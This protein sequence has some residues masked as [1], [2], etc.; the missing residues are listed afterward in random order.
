MKLKDKQVIITGAGGG[1]GSCI[2]IAFA[3]KGAN[4]ALVDRNEEA[5]APV[6]EKA[7]TIGVKAVGINADI[8]TKQGRDLIIKTTEEELG[9]IDI[10]VNNAGIMIFKSIAAHTEEEVMK[11]LTVNVF[12][13]ISLTQAV[14]GGMHAR[15]S[16]RIVN[17]GSIFASL[18]FPY[19]GIYSA[20][21]AAIKNF[22]EGLRRELHGTGIG[23]T[24]VAPRATRTSQTN[25]FFE[26][27]RKMKMNL[28]NPEKVAAIVVKS[29]ENDADEVLI[30][31]PERLF[32][33]INKLRP[34]L[35]DNGLLKQAK[36]MSEYTR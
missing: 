29:I 23:V 31:R 13:T 14:L 6:L 15:G 8:T 33:L 16:G 19:F 12:G 3:E 34:S 18:A 30:G 27:A 36:I 20:S 5:L 22:S 28:D 35:L 26:M 25:E 21:K 7:K 17:I 1:I 11:T 9:P 4:L 32:V 24:Y 2:A 10:L